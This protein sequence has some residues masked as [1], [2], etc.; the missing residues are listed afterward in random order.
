MH[1]FQVKSTASNLNV[2]I[3]GL[4]SFSP[5]NSANYGVLWCDNSSLNS[6]EMCTNLTNTQINAL[7]ITPTATTNSVTFAVP[8]VF[9]NVPAG[10]TEQGQGLVFFVI[11]NQA[12][13]LPISIPKVGIG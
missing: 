13:P 1:L 3:S 4:T 11:T 2:K 5:K 9:P 7:G 10:T 8:G 12:A 6:I